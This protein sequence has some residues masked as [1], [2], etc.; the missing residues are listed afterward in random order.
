MTSERGAVLLICQPL[1]VEG[2]R[3]PEANWHMM[4]AELKALLERPQ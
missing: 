3:H 4:L 2:R 1:N